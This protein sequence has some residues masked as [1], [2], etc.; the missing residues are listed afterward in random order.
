MSSWSS[1]GLRHKRSAS[2][3]SLRAQFKQFLS[4]AL[5]ATVVSF[6][7]A[8]RVRES[9]PTSI[10]L[11]SARAAVRQHKIHGTRH[12]AMGQSNILHL[13]LLQGRGPQLRPSN[14]IVAHAGTN[15]EDLSQ[16]SGLQLFPDS[17]SQLYSI[18]NA[19]SPNSL[20]SCSNPMSATLI[21]PLSPSVT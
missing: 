9:L 10:A 8:F 7:H 12:N 19:S 18:R 6:S 21:S 16:L 17:R 3:F 5:S 11:T 14:F 13:S 15:F 20:R 1:I 2:L 4:L